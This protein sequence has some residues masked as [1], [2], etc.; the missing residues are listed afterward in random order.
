M[1][2]AG[3]SVCFSGN[4]PYCSATCTSAAGKPLMLAE[5]GTNGADKGAWLAGVPKVLWTHNRIKA[6]VQ[7]NS[8][9][10]SCDH[11]VTASPANLAG[12]RT[13]SRMAYVNPRASVKVAGRV[14]AR[15]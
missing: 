14:V 10:G 12:F 4:R 8:K 11:R 15:P 5:Y 9:P 2:I 1:R 6:A 3:A 13:A 7:F